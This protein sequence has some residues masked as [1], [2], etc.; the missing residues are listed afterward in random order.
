MEA[1]AGPTSNFQATTDPDT[2][3][4]D[5][6]YYFINFTQWNNH[7]N[8]IFERLLEMIESS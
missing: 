6:F 5:W 3:M 8:S 1:E 7:Q 4:R 2:E